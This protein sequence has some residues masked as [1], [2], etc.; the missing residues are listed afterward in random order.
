MRMGAEQG[1]WAV[2]GSGEQSELPGAMWETGRMSGL[3]R[4]SPAPLQRWEV[5][6]M[7]GNLCSNR[8]WS[9]AKLEWTAPE[10]EAQDWG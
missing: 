10:C 7:E 2:K 3:Y 6:I 4:S 9:T 1:M 8:E 5:K